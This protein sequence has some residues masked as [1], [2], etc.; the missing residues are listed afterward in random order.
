MQMSRRTEVL[1]SA[2][3]DREGIWSL[4]SCPLNKKSDL[5]DI[6]KSLVRY[7]VQNRNGRSFGFCVVCSVWSIQKTGQDNGFCYCCWLVE[8]LFHPFLLFLLIIH[9]MGITSNSSAV[10]YVLDFL[11]HVTAA[12]QQC[13]VLNLSHQAVHSTFSTFIVC[14]TYT[15]LFSPL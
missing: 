6:Y 10:Y 12:A 4:F 5:V 13:C 1:A 14:Q 11:K 8:S 2:A 3:V 9:H 15:V 7:N